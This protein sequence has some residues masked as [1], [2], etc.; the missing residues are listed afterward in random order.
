MTGVERRVERKVLS[1]K[2]KEVRETGEGGASGACSG[3]GS[4][5]LINGKRTRKGKTI[6]GGDWGGGGR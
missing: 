1:G 6:R 4:R 5:G 3:G 2:E